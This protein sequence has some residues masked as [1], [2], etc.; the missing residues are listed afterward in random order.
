[1]PELDRRDFLKVVGLSA[2]A[3]AAAGCQEPVE[4]VIP[5]LIQPEEIVVGIPTYYS[6]TCRECPAAC[7]THVKTREGRPIKVDGNPDDPVSRG[8]LC[9]RGQASL[10]RTYDAT[11]FP[12]PMRRD[13]ENLVPT[14]WE[15]ALGLLVER[16]GTA[17]RAGRVVF[18]GD[19]ETG[20]LDALVDQFLAAIG[21]PHRVRFELYAHEALRAA[22]QR[23]FGTDA[24]PHFDLE[25]ADFLVSFG[26]DFLETSLD[27][28]QN[29][30]GFTQARRAGQAYAVYVGPRLSLSGSNA[31]LWVSARPGTEILVALA[32]A[33]EVAR[34][35]PGSVPASVRRA[36]E[37]YAPAR[38]AEPAG[39]EAGTLEV[40]A[41]RLAQAQAPLALPPGNEVLGTNGTD[42]ALAVQLLN[43]ASGALGST[44]RFGPD[45]NVS[46]LA[47]FGD[48]KDLAGR[49]RG[50]EVEVLLV[51]NANPV[52]SL[53]QV[54]GFAD[55]VRQVP[56]KVSFSSADDETTALADLVLPDHTPYEAWGD[57]EP[58]RGVRRLQ[59]PTIRPIF[60]TRAIGDV[61]L[62]VGRRLGAG[63]KLPAGSFR[64][65]LATRWS[66][67]GLEQALAK[68]GDFQLAADRPVSL[69][70]DLGDLRFEVA[71]TGGEGKLTLLVYPSLSFH[72]GRSARIA[73]LQELP[74][75]V[76][77]TTWGSYAELHRETAEEL[78]L[79]RGDVVRLSTEVGAI[80]LPVF[81][82]Q[83]IR[84]D[85]IAVA[86]G[87]GHKPVDPGAPAPDL[88]Q[89]RRV[90]GV[91][92][93]SIL[94]GRID[95]DSGGLAW[96]STRVGV[97]R[98]GRRAVVPHT[99]LGFDQEG[100]GIAQAASLAALLG[101]EEEHSEAP[102]LETKEYDPADDALEASPYRWGMSIDL[103]AC[104]GC[105]ACVTACNQENNI[106]AVGPDVVAF[107]R[108]MHWMRIE[109]YVESHD[110]DL[111]VRHVPM[112]CQH[113]GA[114]PCENV[115]PTL[116]TLHGDEGLNM[117]SYNRCIGTRYC[118]NNCP[119]KVR[120]FNYFTHDL[121]VRE[122]EHL[123]MNPDVTVRCKGV[124]EK[125]TFC[126]QR[127]IDAHQVA[128]DEKRDIRD[129]EV[130]PAC[131]QTCPSQAIV[132]GNLRDRESRVAQ[133]RDD[134][135]A[136][137]V[138]EHLY[139]R[140]AVSYLK[141]IGRGGLRK[142]KG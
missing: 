140:P 66:A 39:V 94:P 123:G 29:Q 12:G 41:G 127:I 40:V 84:R 46:G 83:T 43:V 105:G 17:A 67:P 5:Y 77:K 55:A 133:V 57:A 50:G 26:N 120:R 111:E 8:T 4:K 95:P 49:M 20:T 107:G 87:Q 25:R 58:I 42:F 80:E 62:D 137:R 15:E 118:S 73:M 19:L 76:T 53:P 61:L 134:P 79:E 86:V 14:S 101:Y 10:A 6:S 97:E 35:R 63:E 135:R 24:V 22:N 45:H 75:P 51:H 68:G 116:A 96:L 32:L 92:V 31:D 74:D 44:V 129:G 109:R 126:A 34:Q 37:P 47:R 131:A 69:R 38:V 100:R 33:H 48:L 115:C 90:V 18:L 71:E 23:L 2:G 117:M 93:L 114:A 11:R 128:K 89:R 3:A 81:P 141:S 124:M 112:L 125:C 139:T 13:C 91:N 36:L 113:C 106:F 21:S 103:D 27:P 102:H 119:Y 136:Y 132:F 65:L 16:L 121:F 130:K 122:P 72:D 110:G 98:T 1:M 78:G 28:L 59:Q 142:G 9:V 30:I 60:D 88:H 104:T 108:E 138:F 7:G 70:S 54:F 85:A 52:Y 82:H 56:F 64:D 99:Q